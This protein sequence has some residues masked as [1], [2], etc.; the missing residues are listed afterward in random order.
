MAL[1][2]SQVLLSFSSP[3][4]IQTK[5][6]KLKLNCSTSKTLRA[7][8]EQSSNSSAQQKNTLQASQE[9]CS[10]SSAQQMTGKS[11]TTANMG[12]VTPE[13]T[14]TSNMVRGSYDT[15]NT[16]PPQ[17]GPYPEPPKTAPRPIAP[18]PSV[19]KPEQ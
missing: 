12:N 15:T 9:Q 11:R 16:P 6:H 13:G 3:S 5:Q 17:P 18:K 1:F 7:T 19:R 14:V 2:L 10:N 4:Y 8:R